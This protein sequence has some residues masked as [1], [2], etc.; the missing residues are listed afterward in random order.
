MA[1]PDPKLSE[2]DAP[3]SAEALPA[4]QPRQGKMS[5]GLFPVGGGFFPSPLGDLAAAARAHVAQK[6]APSLMPSAGAALRA[7][8]DAGASTP[9]RGLEG[10]RALPDGE[11]GRP[12]CVAGCRVDHRAAA[13]GRHYAPPIGRHAARPPRGYQHHHGLRPAVATRQDSAREPPSRINSK[14]L[15]THAASCRTS[16]SRCR[17]P[18]SRVGA[19]RPRSSGFARGSRSRR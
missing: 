11:R 8:A 13:S 16:S 19:C 4:V 10:G 5:E 18:G 15:Q 7:S 1:E 12:R 6:E 17:R 9:M 3:G 2:T 14:Q